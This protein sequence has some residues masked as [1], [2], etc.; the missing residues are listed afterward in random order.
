MSKTLRRLIVVLAVS[1]YLLGSSLGLQAT[2]IIVKDGQKIVFLGNSITVSGWI[3]STGYVTLTIAGLEANGI[4]VNA[5]PAGIGGQKSNQMLER[6]ERDVLKKKP[7]WM[8]LSCGVNDVWQ[9]AQGIPLDNYKIN[10]TAI[11][12]KCQAAGVKVVILTATVIGEDLD[13]D[14][15]KKL[16][17]Y[18]K[19]LR[20]LAKEKKCLLADVNAMFQKL[21]SANPNPGLVLTSD[22]VHMNTDGDKVMATCILRAFGLNIGQMK[23]AEESWNDIFN[24]EMK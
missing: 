23:K 21:I 18:N 7:D 5:I 19:F 24:Q 14:Y 3:N 16:S 12:D 22:G 20:S 17:S 6:L 2:E 11:I 9:G 15:N 8:I 1:L 4:R 13:N 10:I